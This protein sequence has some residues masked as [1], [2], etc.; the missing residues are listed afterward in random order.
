MCVTVHMKKSEGNLR[1]SFHS[2]RVHPGVC[3]PVTRL[4][5]TCPFLPLSHWSLH[6]VLQ[7]IQIAASC[8]CV[9]QEAELSSAGV[10]QAPAGDA[11]LQEGENHRSSLRE[12]TGKWRAEQDNLHHL[13]LRIGHE[14]GDGYAF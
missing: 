6:Y 7:G 10:C 11:A 13:Q 4:Y 14:S 2:Y 5:D 12:V 9:P 1:E 8:V 3:V